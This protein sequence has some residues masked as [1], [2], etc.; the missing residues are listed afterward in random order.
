[1]ISEAGA[2]PWEGS[3]P[4]KFESTVCRRD[5]GKI[6]NRISATEN[7]KVSQLILKELLKTLAMIVST[8]SR[9]P[10]TEFNGSV[11]VSCD[12]STSL[13]VRHAP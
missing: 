7:W 13:G 9:L 5:H 12:T 10:E 11:S 6:T 2:T 3:G 4:N 8:T 1:M